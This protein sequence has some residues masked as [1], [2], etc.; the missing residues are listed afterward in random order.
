MQGTKKLSFVESIGATTGLF[1]GCP[2]CAGGLFSALFGF[3]SGGTAVT[4][5]APF[6]TLFIAVIF[7][8]FD[9]ITISYR[10]GN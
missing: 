9:N 10:T 6:Q 8:N 5:L 4:L 3:G 1:I 7:Q 2:T